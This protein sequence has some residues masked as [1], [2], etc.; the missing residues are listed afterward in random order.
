MSGK[1][2]ASDAVRVFV[3]PRL[4]STGTLMLKLA[5]YRPCHGHVS[6]AGTD[7]GASLAGFLKQM[8]PKPALDAKG[9]PIPVPT[10]RRCK[11]FAKGGCR[12]GDRCRDDHSRTGTSGSISSGG[13][14]AVAAD[15]EAV[16]FGPWTTDLLEAD[17]TEISKHAR[18]VASVPGT[19]LCQPQKAELYGTYVT[20]WLAFDSFGWSELRPRPQCTMSASSS[21]EHAE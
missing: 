14:A 15:P 1:V 9:N 5:R 20:F 10:R 17:F 6:P 2:K 8:A 18:V 13:A 4:F 7:F 12:Y 16:H 11:W 21:R 19:H 3:P